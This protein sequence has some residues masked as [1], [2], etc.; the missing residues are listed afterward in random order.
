MR[1]IRYI[2]EIKIFLAALIFVGDTDIMIEGSI[3]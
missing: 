2:L 1:Y 3:E